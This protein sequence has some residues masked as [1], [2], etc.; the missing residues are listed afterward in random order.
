MKLSG[1]QE[2]ILGFIQDFVEDNGYPPT[3]RQIGKAVGISSTSVV[4]YNLNVLEIGYV[5]MPF[6][7]DTAFSIRE[8]KE[9]V[10]KMKLRPIE[11]EIKDAGAVLDKVNRMAFIENSRLG[12]LKH[13]F[14]HHTYALCELK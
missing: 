7:P 1:R 14:A 13:F 4:S 2:R 11:R 6:W 3:M 10:L 9:N 5:D 8:V 12:I